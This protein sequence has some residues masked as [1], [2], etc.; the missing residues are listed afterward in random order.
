MTEHW[1]PRHVND[2]LYREPAPESLT[3]PEKVK[4]ALEDH[5]RSIKQFRA[6]SDYPAS[7][8]AYG[9]AE[10]RFFMTQADLFCAIEDA[11]LVSAERLQ[12]ALAA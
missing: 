5:E 1:N 2:P 7:D 8:A 4:R 6:V 12:R 9:R 10:T 11:C 3:L